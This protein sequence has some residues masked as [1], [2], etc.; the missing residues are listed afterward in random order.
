MYCYDELHCG[1]FFI[2]CSFIWFRNSVKFQKLSKI[3][4]VF[5]R[6]VSAGSFVF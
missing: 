3:F 2:N 5:R 4:V 1:E 6:F